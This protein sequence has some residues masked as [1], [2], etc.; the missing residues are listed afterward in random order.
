[1]GGSVAA[2]MWVV[3]DVPVGDDFLPPRG[4]SRCEVEQAADPSL[5]QLP[6]GRRSCFV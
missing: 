2:C 4:S 1:M 6:R 3:P 5:P